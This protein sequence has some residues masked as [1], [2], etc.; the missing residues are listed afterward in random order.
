M[1]RALLALA[2]LLSLSGAA[3]GQSWP[4]ERP[5]RPLEPHPV[6]FAHYEL[7][8]LPNGLNVVVVRQSE[9]PVISVR[10]LIRAGS[11]QDP[12]SK[13][14]VASMVAALLDQGTA[15]RSASDIA[16]AIDFMGGGL[17]LGAGTDLSYANTILLQSN[18]RR[19]CSSSPT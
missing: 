14:G 16:D 18:S 19:A 15:T 17:G 1:R 5:P 12:A 7:R 13:P 11:A 3:A 2:L 8:T 10:M 6:N 4:S 9:Q